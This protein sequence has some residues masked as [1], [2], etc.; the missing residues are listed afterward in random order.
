MAAIRMMFCLWPW[1]TA[2]KITVVPEP[3]SLAVFGVAL[4]GLAILRRKRRT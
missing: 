3:A 2:V 1:A 4:A